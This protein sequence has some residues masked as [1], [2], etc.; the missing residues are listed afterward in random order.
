[1]VTLSLSPPK[2]AMLSCIH[3]KA[4]LWSFK[5]KLVLPEFWKYVSRCPERHHFYSTYQYLSGGEEAKEGKAIVDANSNDWFAHGHGLIHHVAHVV[6]WQ[7]RVS[8]ELI[9]RIETLQI[10]RTHVLV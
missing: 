7:G 5:P 2:A 9:R 6:K 1:M 3:L 10:C 8:L 4:C